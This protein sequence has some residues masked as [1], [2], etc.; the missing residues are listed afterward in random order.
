MK[1]AQTKNCVN[2]QKDFTIE[3]DDFGFYEQMKVPPPT[4]CPH[5]RLVRRLAWQGYRFLYKRECDFSKEK[6][7]STIPPD[8]LHKV[9]KQDIWWSDK[10]DPKSYGRDYDSSRPFFE[11]WKDL[12]MDV[13]LPS[14][15]T[16]YSTMIGSDYCNAAATL[17]NCYL[18]FKF[19][20]SEE[21]GYCN[22][23]TSLKNSFDVSFSNFCE[24]CYDSSNLNKCNQVFFSQDCE[25]SYNIW[26]SRDLVGCND[27]V[28]CI[29]LR[30]KSYHIFNK[31]YSKE[32]Y[33]TIIKEYDFK[34][35]K[36]ISLFKRETEDFMLT[37]P[38]RQF[39]GYQNQ[40]VS[41][42]YIYKSRNIK[43]SYMVRNSENLRYCH[44]L[45]AG[46]VFNAMD[47][48]TFG[49]K[50]EWIYECGWVGIQAN[51]NKFCIWCY[52]S[53]NLEYCF[54]CHG[55]GNL[56]GC[57][58]I[59]TGEYCILNKQYTK[60]DY[61]IIVEKIKKE[62]KEYGEMLPISL[63]PWPYNESNADEWFPLSKDEALTQGFSWRDPDMREYVDATIILPDH[64]KN[65]SDDITKE[66]L[67]CIDCGRNYQ[68]IHKELQFYKRF[69]LPIPKQCPLCRDR[70]RV[71]KMNPLQIYYRNCDKC[72]LDIT[73]SYAPERPEIVYC[74]KCYQQQ[75]Y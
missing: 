12:V 39:H 69:N 32:D 1:E 41:G 74:E 26:F 48:T 59:R 14:L 43:D 34:T 3:P 4:W 35:L 60:E 23:G 17:K 11:Q 16:E 54:G 6:V 40:N 31:A 27:C 25:D 9:Y 30:N 72:H 28:G 29:N 10:W 73:T 45:K 15:T 8:S 63:C 50:A 47:Y 42:D 62:M 38:R 51:N 57:V 68:I 46:N 64:I 36:G 65:V 61:S 19:D 13:P 5:C 33:R 70:A 52:K 22:T 2:C 71:K 66:I 21:C 58:G 49:M 53:H 24:L 18:C 7:L 75:V 20:E 44:L 56:F 37:Q 55:S 67:K